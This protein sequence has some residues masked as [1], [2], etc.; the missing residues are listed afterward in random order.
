MDGIEFPNCH[1]RIWFRNCY[2][3]CLYDVN[4][5]CYHGRSF[6]HFSLNH[7]IRFHLPVRTLPECQMDVHCL[8]LTMDGNGVDYLSDVNVDWL[9]VGSLVVPVVLEGV[10]EFVAAN[11]GYAV[12][13]PVVLV[14]ATVVVA[15]DGVQAMIDQTSHY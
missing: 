9:A 13:V 11:C 1:S 14:A 15:V 10:A 8:L 12:A 6:V 4:A 2:S 3:T 7:R 5:C